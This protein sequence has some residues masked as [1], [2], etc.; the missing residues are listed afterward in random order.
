M[1][2]PK[3]ARHPPSLKGI[4]LNTTWAFQT[5]TLSEEILGSSD[6]TPGQEYVF[7]RR[8]VINEEIWVNELS[9]LSSGE[10]SELMEK[11]PSSVSEAKDADGNTT[12][13]WVKWKR[14]DDFLNSKQGDRHYVLD[15][16]M[17]TV[18]VGDGINGRVPPIGRDNIKANY[19]TGGGMAGNVNAGEIASLKSSL[20]FIDGVTNPEMADGGAD[21]EAL[22]E[23]LIRGPQHIKN[24]AHAVAREDFEWMALEASRK[25]VR[26]K[27]IPALDKECRFKPGW[28]TLIIVPQ[29]SEKMP[30]PS[31]GLKGLVMKYVEERSA[32]VLTVPQ[33][34]VVKGPGYLGVS[35]SAVLIARSIDRIPLI[36]K[37]ARLK[38]RKFLHPLTGGNMGGGWEF[39]RLPCLSDFYRIL[40]GIDGVDH[41]EGLSMEVRGAKKDEKIVITP[42]SEFYPQLKQYN[43]VFSGE[44]DITAAIRGV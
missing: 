3:V 7:S 37:D 16:T 33:R 2:K 17:G 27:C 20:P 5:E 29:S 23:L 18:N 44:H 19:Q 30:V 22:D 39:G 12:E 26:A 40:E 43:L 25:I 32:G 42:E 15:G 41:V 9:S 6:G 24:R 8:P 28:V 10:R 31:V 34:L 38:V 11:T 35:I 36:E 1:R 14:V 21:T 13:F 4:H